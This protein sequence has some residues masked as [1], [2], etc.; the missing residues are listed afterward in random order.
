[1]EDENE[2]KFFSTY[3]PDRKRNYYEVLGVPKNSN[4]DDIKRAHRRLAL[5]YHP[6]NNPG[7]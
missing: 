2:Q 6:K 7:K 5:Q 3:Y 1:M 4:F